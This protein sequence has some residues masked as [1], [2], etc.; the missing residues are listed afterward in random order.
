MKYIHSMGVCKGM[1]SLEMD[2]SGRRL[3]RLIRLSELIK[4]TEMLQATLQLFRRVA[5]CTPILVVIA[6]DRKSQANNPPTTAAK[7]PTAVNTADVAKKSDQGKQTEAARPHQGDVYLSQESGKPVLTFLSGEEVEFRTDGQNF[8]CK[9]NYSEDGQLRLV[10]KTDQ[11]ATKAVYFKVGKL[12]L[13]MQLDRVLFT[14]AGIRQTKMQDE[15]VNNTSAT[16][17]P[18][19]LEAA[20]NDGFDINWTDDTDRTLLSRLAVY[21]Q[22]AQVTFSLKKGADVNMQGITGETALHAAAQNGNIKMLQAMLD[23]GGDVNKSN[24]AGSTPLFAAA[25]SGAPDVVRLLLSHGAKATQKGKYNDTPLH[26][27]S[28]GLEDRN[29][30][31]PEKE[32]EALDR[33]R[34]VISILVKE[35]VD[36]NATDQRGRTPVGAAKDNGCPRIIPLLTAA[37]GH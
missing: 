33:M 4:G 35:G 6:C 10:L 18:E 28:G 36:I 23:H 7:S 11:G 34:E 29:S 17:F 21:G 1:E 8:I 30:L 19:K 31:T 16:N 3:A 13:A 20:L 24:L 12:R 25:R 14:V 5:F 26:T 27:L 22:E 9:Y 15:L 2:Q 37:G 32:K